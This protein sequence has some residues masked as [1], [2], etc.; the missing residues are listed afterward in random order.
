MYI[1]RWVDWCCADWIIEIEMEDFLATSTKGN[2]C[3]LIFFICNNSY[4]ASWT[5]NNSYK[6]VSFSR[7]THT[8]VHIL[9]DT[10]AL[11]MAVLFFSWTTDWPKAMM[12][13]SGPLFLHHLS[14]ITGGQKRSMND[15]LL[16]GT[17]SCSKTRF[18]WRASGVEHICICT[19][20]K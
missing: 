6:S 18:L 8:H 2:Y 16:R 5:T 7:G 11:T 1:I 3:L 20:R 10:V 15:A 9:P 12:C 13:A 19:N 4:A 14:P 17:V